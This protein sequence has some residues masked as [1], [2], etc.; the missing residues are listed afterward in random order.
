MKKAK[1]PVQAVETTIDILETLKTSNGD[2]VTSVAERLGLSK[3][4]VH[5]HLS[6]LEERGFV[7]RKGD[8]F[9]VSMR[10]F[11]FGEFAKTQLPVYE[12]GVPEVEELA[13][14]TGEL[15][16]LLVEENGWGIYLHR[17]RGERALHLDTGIGSR[18]HL[19]STALGKA[20]LA[21]LSESRVTAII[22][23]R[24]LPRFTENTITDRDRLWDE[25]ETIREQGYALDDR[26]RTEEVVCVAAP[27]LTT[28]EDVLG[29]VSVA[30]PASR[31]K[32]DHSIEDLAELVRKT[33]NVIGINATY[34]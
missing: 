26:E 29:A 18:V 16:N 19:H 23:R 1:N 22:E 31:M 3:G 10:F 17:A 13:R 32:T 30:G 6:T 2:S 20:I 7:T 24:G 12:F 21:Y 25:L 11:E 14:E 28:D 8:E 4:T 9:H 27:V 15:G 34:A 33:G 5:N